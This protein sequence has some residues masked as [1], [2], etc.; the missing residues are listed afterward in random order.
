MNPTPEL[1]A[2][3]RA[4][5]AEFIKI[6]QYDPPQPWDE[7][8]AEFEF[9]R[10]AAFQIAKAVLLALQEPTEGMLHAAFVAMNETPSGTWKR[11]KAEGQTPRRL[12]DVKMAPRWRAMIGYVLGERK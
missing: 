11:M 6:D 1:E 12:F 5:Y 7:N 4:I 9:V 2:V 8:D 10:D 3:A